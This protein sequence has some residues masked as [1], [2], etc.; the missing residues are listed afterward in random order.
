[1][2]TTTPTGLVDYPL[3]SLGA[4]MDEG[5]LLE[6][7]VE[8]GQAVEAGDIVALVDTE[9]SE[10]EIE[11]FHPG[12]VAELLLE[13][14]VTVPVGTVIARFAP[15]DEVAATPPTPAPPV[16]A[17]AP[18]APSPAPTGHVL[19][20]A[21]AGLRPGTTPRRHR[22]PVV[23]QPTPS[24][25]AKSDRGA[26]LR[27][28]I[29]QQMARSK[30]EIPH[31][32][33]AADID[34]AT[35]LEWMQRYNDSHEV[36]DRLLAASLLLTATARAAAATPGLNGTFADDAFSPADSVHLGVAV[37][38]RG[39]GLVA[40]A[41]LD[42]QDRSVPDLMAALRDLV[43]RARAGRLRDREMKSQTITVTNLGEQGVE[44]VHPIINPPQVAMI[45]F[46]RITDRPVVL[47]GR[48]VV[49]PVVTASVSADHRVSDGIV[50]A[51]F[52]NTLDRL[53]QR[54]EEL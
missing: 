9:K 6:W 51:R 16:E 41:I 38:L 54:P 21:L 34:L 18:V 50:A 8:V 43:A 17:T 14:G 13:V 1:M 31:Y 45:G 47:D 23:A 42:A 29:G 30:R 26:A 32:Y 35:S 27:R 22:G 2:S 11:T 3:P 25:A 28:R 15:A 44:V 12:T 19:A 7:R 5:T 46:G 53:L 4:D 48:V 37:S 10:I 36:G 20:T 49:H 52:L 33:V 40:P 39:G 24:V